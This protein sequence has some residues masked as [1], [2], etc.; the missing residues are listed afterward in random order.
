MQNLL[1]VKKKGILTQYS[2]SFPKRTTK[3]RLSKTRLGKAQVALSTVETGEKKILIKRPQK[4]FLQP[5]KG[6]RSE[7]KERPFNKTTEPLKKD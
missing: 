2:V 3:Y 1:T 4:G 6:K 7:P 5:K